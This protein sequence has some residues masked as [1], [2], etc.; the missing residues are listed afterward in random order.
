MRRYNG[1]GR[2]CVRTSPDAGEELTVMELTVM[3]ATGGEL[4]I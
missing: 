3:T 4:A 2:H 1:Q